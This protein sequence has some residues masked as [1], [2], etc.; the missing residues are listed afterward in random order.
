MILKYLG[1]FIQK[2]TVSF[3][4]PITSLHLK[5]SPPASADCERSPWLK[6][7][8]EPVS[9]SRRRVVAKRKDIIGRTD[10]SRVP[11][12]QEGTVR[13]ERGLMQY[14]LWP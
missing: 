10:R 2:Q 12:A 14:L 5:M 3:T 9:W 4:I 6:Q 8:E 7:G 13:K 11:I 1:S